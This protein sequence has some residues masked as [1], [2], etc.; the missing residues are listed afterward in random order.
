MRRAVV[1]LTLAACNQAAAPALP[2]LPA[3]VTPLDRA[4]RRQK[5]NGQA[6]VWALAR[7]RNAFVGKLELAPDGK[8][9]EHRDPTEEY[10]HILEGGGTFTIDGVAHPVGPGTTIYMPPDALVSFANGPHRLVAL[11]VFAGPEPAAKYDAWSPV[12]P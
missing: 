12:A 1:L 10:I 2:A 3:A 5:G 11:Q 9:P 7:G 8:V 6:Q 4:E